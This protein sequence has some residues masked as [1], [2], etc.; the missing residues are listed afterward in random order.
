MMIR[1][2]RRLEVCSEIKEKEIAK[3]IRE[4]HEKSACDPCHRNLRRGC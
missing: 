2:R 3:M 1:M 4:L